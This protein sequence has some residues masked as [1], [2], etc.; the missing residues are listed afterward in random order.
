MTLLGIVA[1]AGLVQGNEMAWQMA[2]LTAA[3]AFMTE[4]LRTAGNQ[5]S[6]DQF[7]SF[8]FHAV[9]FGTALA[10]WVAAVAA[11]TSLL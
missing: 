4:E 5:F 2:G 8:F 10:S 9:A 11:A 7:P 6:G 1:A 3:L